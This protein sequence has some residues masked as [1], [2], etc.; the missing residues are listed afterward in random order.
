[1]FSCNEHNRYIS[2]IFIFL[3]ITTNFKSVRARHE[4]IKKN[5]VWKNVR[6]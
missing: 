3:Y 6:Q 1:M 4:Y 5:Y 2:C